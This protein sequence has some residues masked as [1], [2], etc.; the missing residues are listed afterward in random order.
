M[1]NIVRTLDN[2]EAEQST[3]CFTLN[4]D[5]TSNALLLI[6]IETLVIISKL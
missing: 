5:L 3:K 6:I 2:L 4:G 1:Y